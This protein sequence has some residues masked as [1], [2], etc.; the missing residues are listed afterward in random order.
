MLISSPVIFKITLADASI[1]SV[2]ESRQ[3]IKTEIIL[4]DLMISYPPV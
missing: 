3:K 1:K 4:M 2:I